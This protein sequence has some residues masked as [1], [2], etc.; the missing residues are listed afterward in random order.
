LRQPQ[1]T[2]ALSNLHLSTPT[3]LR[4]SLTPLKNES[5]SKA[6]P[7]SQPVRPARVPRRTQSPVPISI[8]TTLSQCS[9]RQEPEVSTHD[10]TNALPV[11]RMSSASLPTSANTPQPIATTSH[12]KSSLIYLASS[13]PFGMV[14]LHI[15]L[16]P[17]S[18]QGSPGEA[19]DL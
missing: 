8:L 10:M 3:T 2:T 6:S 17:S 7:R 4:S 14:L 16:A 18:E 19:D 11:L 13:G 15:L 1:F 12:L 5:K 9:V